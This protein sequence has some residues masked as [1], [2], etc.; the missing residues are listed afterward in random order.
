M[1][2]FT[3]DVIFVAAGPASLCA[4]IGAAQRG[5]RRIPI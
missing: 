2:E 4:A 3:G 5:L 1:S